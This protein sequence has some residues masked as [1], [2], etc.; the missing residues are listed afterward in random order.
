MHSS[1][2]VISRIADAT[3]IWGLVFAAFH[4]YW[5]A[6][7]GA[8][9]VGE[10]SP[11]LAASLYIGLVAVIGLAGSAV[12]LGLNRPWGAAVGRRGLQLLARFGGAALLLGV[13]VGV[14]RWISAGSLGDDG[15]GGIVVTAYFFLGGVLFTLL[16]WH[17]E[18][19]LRADA[20]PPQPVHD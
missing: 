19:L 1:K 15:A 3:A 16:G 10:D 6:G 4:F 14:G 17:G 7:G 12:A 20:R 8:L 5:A 11:S 9:G 2:S 13:A 18:R